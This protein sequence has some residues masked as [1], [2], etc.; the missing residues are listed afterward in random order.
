MPNISITYKNNKHSLG[1]KSDIRNTISKDLPQSEN[2]LKK[3]PTK[4]PKDS[5]CLYKNSASSKQHQRHSYSSS[6]TILPVQPKLIQMRWELRNYF[7]VPMY[8]LMNVSKIHR[9]I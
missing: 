8:Y 1:Q 6:S 5:I 3:K 9:I 2:T 4:T 7:Y